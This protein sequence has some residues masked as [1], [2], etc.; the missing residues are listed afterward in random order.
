MAEWLQLEGYL[1]EAGLPVSVAGAGGRYEADIVGARIRGG[2]LEVFHV[3]CGQLSGGTQSVN[4][5]QKK[6]S[7]NNCARI[8]NYF[9]QRL[10]FAGTNVKYHKMYVASFWTKPTMQGARN[11][12]INVRPLTDFIRNEVIQTINGWK[13]NPPQ[14]P[15]TKGSHI[16]LPESC[17]LLQL[18]DYIYNKGLLK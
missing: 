10:G 15:R 16:T 18:I 11:L 4:S 1:V 2:M 13:A 8:E 5:L 3:E 17:W 14:Q 7:P 12:G 6:F 9:R